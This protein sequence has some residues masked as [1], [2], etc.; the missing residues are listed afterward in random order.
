MKTWVNPQYFHGKEELLSRFSLGRPEA[1]FLCGNSII[2][3][4]SFGKM[5]LNL[6]FLHT[7][8]S[9]IFQWRAVL[10]SKFSMEKLRYSATFSWKTDNS[11]IGNSA[12]L[13][14]FSIKTEL[15]SKFSMKNYS[16]YK[17]FRG[18]LGWMAEVF[19]ESF[20]I[21]LILLSSKFS[22]KRQLF[23][24]FSMENSSI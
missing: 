10:L 9:P 19:M 1:N 7:I 24:S 12:A 17:F 3:Q 2:W 16:I 15:F 14:K 6:Q 13:N 20:L 23:S 22:G 21:F 11:L 5:C 4:F 8:F 18:N